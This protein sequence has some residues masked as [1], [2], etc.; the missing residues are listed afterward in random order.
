M[1]DLDLVGGQP[2]LLDREPPH[3]VADR[4]DARSP[5]GQR[6]LDEPERPRAERIGVVLRRD[7][8]GARHE[9]A[10]DVGVDEVRVDEVGSLGGA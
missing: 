10:V 9:R 3:G 6:A 2:D 4:D 8:A 7:D 5:P 1:D